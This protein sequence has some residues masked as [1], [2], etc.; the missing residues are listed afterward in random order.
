MSCMME[1]S[2]WP[3]CSTALS[4]RSCTHTTLSA[5]TPRIQRRA[6]LYPFGGNRAWP[7]S[8]LSNLRWWWARLRTLC[9]MDVINCHYVLRW[10][11][12]FTFWVYS[13]CLLNSLL[14]RTLSPLRRRRRNHNNI[15]NDEWQKM[16][17]STERWFGCELPYCVLRVIKNYFESNN[18]ATCYIR[19][20]WNSTQWAVKQ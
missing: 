17:E 5:C 6:S 9:S 12:S 1:I 16:D 7:P 3:Y 19:M 15:H 11:I 10:C 2:T 14:T 13:S 20:L 18:L 8:S 4:I